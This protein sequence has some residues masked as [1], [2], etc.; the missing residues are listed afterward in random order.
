MTTALLNNRYQTI[1]LL[2]AGGFGET[3][4]AAD[5]YLPSRRPCVVKQLKPVANDLQ[6]YQ[7][8]QDRFQREAATLEALSAGSDQIPKLYAY[9]SENGQ[10]Y[11]IQE[12]I[13]GETLTRKVTSEGVLSEATVWKILVSLLKVLHYVHSKG[14]IYRDIKPDNIILRQPD[15]QPVMIDFGAV[16]ETMA[17]AIAAQGRSIYTMVL[18]TPG[19]MAPEQAVGRPIYASDIYSLG[20]TAIYLLTGKLPQELEVD[21]HTE[22]V[23]W[24]QYATNVSP[25]LAA[26][27][28]KAVEYQ[29][30]DRYSTAI[31]MLNDLQSVDTISSR[32][33]VDR[34]AI[35]SPHQQTLET[36]TLPPP[37]IRPGSGKKQKY[38][39]FGGLLI[40]G[41]LSTATVFSLVPQPA[42]RSSVLPVSPPTPVSVDLPVS[43]D[44]SPQP[45]LQ[46]GATERESPQP[47]L[48][49]GATERESPQ[50]PLQKG[51]TD[52]N[53]PASPVAAR[54]PQPPL[55]R[56]ATER[57]SPQPPLQRGTRGD[58]DRDIPGFPIG[59]TENVVK[60]TLGNPTKTSRGL[61]VNTR[62]AIYDIEPERIT[63]GY[64]FDRTSGRL[65]QT[66]VSFAQSV[67]PE[68]MQTTLQRML[69]DRTTPEIT[70]GLQ[71]V[72][73][74]QTNRYSF[75]QGQLKGAIERNS[76][77]RIY[78]GIWDADLH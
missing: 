29:P 74:R 14:I 57:E 58:R 37:T 47:P 20:M 30:R 66:E 78:I 70:K 62:A 53:S 38:L 59:T 6:L 19:F 35:A 71:Q 61:W 10:F 63:L 45:S 48:Q 34:D 73:Q 4:L 17:T 43:T 7:I 75:R 31:K 72:Y 44:R 32:Q 55:Q 33:E 27:L 22:R 8:I 9:F 3:F 39:I 49:K 13:E 46:K 56:G 16:K 51:A 12:W 24:Q 11:L 69:R 23:I 15:C 5:T 77:D 41:L 40:G 67:A 18:G 25:S 76:R 28:N 42:P 65:R 50:P 68:T 60:A 64:L 52:Q 54:S 2:G 36:R 26:V 21:P 1:K